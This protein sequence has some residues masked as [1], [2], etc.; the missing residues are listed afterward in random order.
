MTP[1]IHGLRYIPEYLNAAAHD[2]LL[3]EADSQRWLM[4]VDHRV[5]IYGYNYSD[6]KRAPI[7]IGDLPEWVTNLAERLCDDGL[8][9]K[10]PNQM[11]ANDYPPGLASSLTS[12]R[13]SLGT[14]SRR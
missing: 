9:P 14:S 2:R 3:A 4:S 10:V 13:Q 5:Q 11:I 12:T 1:S 6:A 8:L 7:R